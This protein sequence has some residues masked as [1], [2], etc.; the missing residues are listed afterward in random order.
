MIEE[1]K[2][3]DIES[4]YQKYY[5]SKEVLDEY[6]D[7]LIKNEFCFIGNEDEKKRF[8]AMSLDW[9]MPSQITNA[10]ID[11]NKNSEYKIDTAV[12]MLDDLNCLHLQVWIYG[13]F[14]KKKI[15]EIL[16]KVEETSIITLEII[17]DYNNF[18]NKEEIENLPEK[19]KRISNIVAY[20]YNV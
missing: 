6:F 14:D 18:E 9:D 10:I 8:P 1:T 16:E 4:I 2:Q 7:F 13:I 11:I 17:F 19:Y 20:I 5:E 3:T 12:K 15:F